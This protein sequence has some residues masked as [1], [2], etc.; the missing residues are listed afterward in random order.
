[1]TGA[2]RLGWGRL[3]RSESGATAAL[4]TVLANVLVLALNIATGMITAR[5]LGPAGRGEQ[6]A[7]IMWPVL[8]AGA[9]TLGVP[10]ALLY[11]VK[12]DPDQSASLFGAAIVLSLILGSAA[13]VVGVLL[14]PLWL[15][16]YEP[17]VIRFAQWTALSTPL[18][19]IWMVISAGLQAREDFRAFNRSRFLTPLCTVV[20]LIVL[21]HTGHFTP[22]TSAFVILW[23]GFP[24]FVGLVVHAWRLYR[25]RWRGLRPAAQRLV[26]YGTRSYG[27][28]LV[29]TLAS[30]VDQVLVVGLLAPAA[31]GLYVVALSLARVLNVIQTALCVVLFPKATGRAPDEVLTLTGRAVRVSMALT[32]VGAIAAVLLAPFGL[33]LLY[34]PQFL[35]ALPVFRILVPEVLLSGVAAVLTQA[36]MA[37]G[38]PG[39]VT[40]VQVSSFA[41]A[42]LMMLI[43]I[44]RHGLI[45]AGLAL[46]LATSVRLGLLLLCYPLLLKTRPPSLLLSRTDLR[47]LRHSLQGQCA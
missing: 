19:L 27:I 29:S 2:L 44:P 42:L 8:L 3:A 11:N 45:G 16:R 9:M 35:A 22:F 7:M 15:A 25:P 38:R 18:P 10:T 33:R 36:W 31:V 32:L 39:T 12:R 43:L 34:G 6:A 26:H 37:L 41:L 5:A 14:I 30:Q 17:A 21:A 13:A 46:L 1:M 4:Q 40:L 24:I 47:W 20:C 28:D 23:S